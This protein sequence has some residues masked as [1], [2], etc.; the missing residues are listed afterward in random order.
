MYCRTTRFW[1]VYCRITR[2]W[3]VYC[4]LGIRLLWCK[5][6][7]VALLVIT[8]I[9]GMFPRMRRFWVCQHQ[10]TWI[11]GNAKLVR[12]FWVVFPGM[13]RFWDMTAGCERFQ[14]CSRDVA[15]IWVWEHVNAGI[16]GMIP[17]LGG[18]QVVGRKCR[19]NLELFLVKGSA[20]L[21]H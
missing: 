13:W 2:F 6:S 4:H 9:S 14:V 20:K 12:R 15:G 19:G 11:L 1:V 7:W 18:I 16:L 5:R 8:A 10:N 17:D 21:N 3:V